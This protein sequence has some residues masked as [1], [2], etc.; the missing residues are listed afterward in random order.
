MK[1]LM[2]FLNNTLKLSHPSKGLFLVTRNLADRSYEVTQS[3]PNSI[4][5]Y[6]ASV[7]PSASNLSPRSSEA[8]SSSSLSPRSNAIVDKYEETERTLD[9][10]HSGIDSKL[11]NILD[12]YSKGG[13]VNLSEGVH[14]IVRD[15]S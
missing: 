5:Q 10:L 8:S 2:T 11:I 14:S 12:H 1:N 15:Y 3:T 9:S 4:T 6:D 7:A 13:K